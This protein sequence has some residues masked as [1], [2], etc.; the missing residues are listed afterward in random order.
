MQ[1]IKIGD[2]RYRLKK[3]F[4]SILFFKTPAIRI[5]PIDKLL[6][7]LKEKIRLVKNTR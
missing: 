6:I 1:R 3:R 5:S 7:A 2:L 4:C